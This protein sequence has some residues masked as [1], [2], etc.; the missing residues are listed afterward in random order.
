[1]PPRD[2]DFPVFAYRGARA[3]VLLH[4]KH[5]TSFVATWSD[6]SALGVE[7]PE[8]PDAKFASIDHLLVHVLWAARAYLLWCCAGLGIEAPNIDEAPS[9]EQAPDK[10]HAYLQHVIDHWRVPFVGIPKER[11]FDL[12]ITT[13]F[14]RVDPVSVEAMLEHAVVHALRHELQVRELIP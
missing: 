12:H 7:L 4:E 1:M 10:V 11:F 2:Q 5:L 6:A 14:D 8:D 3:L 9:P 13:G